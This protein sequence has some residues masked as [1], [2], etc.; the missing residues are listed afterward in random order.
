MPSFLLKI[1]IIYDIYHQHVPTTADAKFSELLQ[2]SIPAPKC[3]TIFEFKL[4][5][6]L[7]RCIFVWLFFNLIAIRS[8]TFVQFWKQ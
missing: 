7:I 8:F 1:S 5:I 3:A 4:L 6:L 2:L